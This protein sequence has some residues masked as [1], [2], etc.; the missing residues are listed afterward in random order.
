[1]NLKSYDITTTRTYSSTEAPSL[2]INPKGTLIFSKNLALGIGLEAKKRIIIHQDTDTRRDWYIEITDAKN[3]LTIRNY[4]GMICTQAKSVVTEM[5]KAAGVK[6]DRKGLR[7][8]VKIKPF[9]H[10]GR[11]LY[12]INISNNPVENL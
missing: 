10:N 9:I 12:H 11:N 6:I 2:Y 7:F 8:P 5:F 4:A 3:G 1:M